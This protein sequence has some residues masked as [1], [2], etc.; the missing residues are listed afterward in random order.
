MTNTFVPYVQPYC[1]IGNSVLIVYLKFHMTG[2]PVVYLATPSLCP[3]LLTVLPPPSWVS[4]AHPFAQVRWAGSTGLDTH[5][6]M[7]WPP[8]HSLV[9]SRKAP[10]PIQEA[11]QPWG[12]PPP[13]MTLGTCPRPPS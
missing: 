12:P 8:G 6:S 7:A 1:S 4:S 9:N 11:R 13:G 2:H 10:W 5:C 3:T